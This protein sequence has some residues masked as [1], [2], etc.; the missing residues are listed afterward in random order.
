MV[1]GEVDQIYGPNA[2]TLHDEEPFDGEDLLVI[3]NAGRTV[4]DDENVVVVGEVRSLTV[5]DIE[6][7]YSLDW[8]DLDIDVQA[9]P[10]Y[11]QRPVLVLREI[12]PD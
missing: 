10:E 9:E 8:D 11:E 5:A 3:G 2:F 6:R 12:Y 1:E 4:S 7:D